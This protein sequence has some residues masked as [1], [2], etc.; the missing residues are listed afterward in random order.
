MKRGG[1]SIRVLIV[2]D[3]EDDTLLVVRELERGGYAVEWAR[4]DTAAAMTEALATGDWNAVLSDFSMPSFS[5]PAAL[6]LLHA[7]GRDL[8]FIIV[9]GT[10]GEDAAVAAMKAGAHDFLAKHNLA[11]LVAAVERELREADERAGRQAAEASLRAS[12]EHLRAILD[13]AL[14]GI[15]TFD[16]TGLIESANP[17]AERIF[18]YAVAELV[19]RPL[20]D[21]VFAAD[22]GD[23][24][25]DA[26]RQPG[27]RD[28]VGRRKSGQAFPMGV[29]VSTTQGSSQRLGIAIVRDVTEPRELEAQ[30]RQM[31]K[32]ETIGRLAGG[33]AH[34]FNNLLAVILSYAS[35]AL[36]GL[37]AG[38][39]LRAD[40]DEIVHA[41]QRAAGLTRQLLAFSRRQV[42]SPQVVELSG[43]IADMNKLLGRLIGEDIELA[44]APGR[45]L[46]AVRADRGQLE[47]ILMN[48]V[49]NARDAMPEG[50]R[51]T[52][53]T[54][55]AEVDAER[56]LRFGVVAGPYVRFSVIDTGIG[57]SHE[58]RAHLFEPFFTSKA[59]GKGTGLG[60]A[61][62]HGIVKRAG[63]FIDVDS[64]EGRGSRFDVHLPRLAADNVAAR[65][66][67]QTLS[68]G[69]ETV[70]VVEDE[71][72]LREVTVRSLRSLGYGVLE[73]AEGNDA[74]HVAERFAG[75]IDLLL[76]DVV[77]PGLGGRK[78]AEQLCAM[79]PELKVLYTS[80]YADRAFL[81]QTALKS[82]PGF[83]QKP[84][85][86]ASL[87]AKVREALD[88]PAPIS[89]APE[90][91]LSTAS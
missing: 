87:A 42:L 19:G 12:E 45:D 23:A 76:S 16:P 49:V 52:I 35:I 40:L 20:Q 86:L 56:A 25:P 14:D 84:F 90:P 27:A 74:L 60:L 73:A 81:K 72:A 78:L 48:L 70:L 43:L 63:G 33:I 24:S 64:T 68:G 88:E 54:A 79:R 51:V 18:G 80:G 69:S 11:R 15:L 30:V 44:I 77:M 53:E 7:S 26:L 17:A 34:D 8:P 62:S 1:K 85:S 38:T 39:R 10:I 37:P 46:G 75:R 2:E 5:A 89:S 13:N 59:L 28:L 29:S 21:L 3:S 71:P 55:N 32:T 41:A 66:G 22:E 67:R 36:R 82:T 57:I 31:L 83:L 9:S 58:V 6:A 50:G 47:Q 4:V 61:T 91:R 65:D